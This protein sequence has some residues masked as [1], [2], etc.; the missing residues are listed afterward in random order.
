MRSA[1]CHIT[2]SRLSDGQWLQASLPV[3]EEGIG[4]RR[5][6]SLA[7]PAFLAS[8]ASTLSLQ[9]LILAGCSLSLITGIPIRLVDPVWHTA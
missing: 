2:N 3:K 6:A 9:A 4:V 5:V 7:F 1:V 8:T